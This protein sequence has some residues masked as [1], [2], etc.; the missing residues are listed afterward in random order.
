MQLDKEMRMRA[1]R[2]EIAKP[3]PPLTWDQLGTMLRVQRR[4]VPQIM[5]AGM[6]ARIACGVVKTEA[7]KAVVCPETKGASPQAVVYQAMQSELER[8]K[9]GKWPDATRPALDLCSGMV[10]ACSQRVAQS[11]AKRPGFNGAQP[12]PVRKQELKVVESEGAVTI[13]MKLVSDGRV[14]VIARPSKGT[15]WSTLRAIA[16]GTIAHGDCKVV[17]DEDRKKWYALISY[18]APV[19]ADAAVSPERALVVHRGV[20][21][22]LTLMSTTGAVRSES[23]AKLFHQLTSLEARMKETRR[24]S[25]EVIGAGSR[26]HGKSRRY[27]HYDAL[28]GKRANVVKTWCQQMGALVTRVAAENGCGTVVIEEYGGIAPHEDAHVRR[29]LI[30]FPMFQLKQAIKNACETRGL[31]LDEAPS[32][33]VSSTCPACG[34]LDFRQHNTRTGTFHCRQCSLERPADFV[35]TLN[36]LRRS[37]VDSTVWDERM[38]KV[39]KLKREILAADNAAE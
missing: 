25:P 15:H 39:E 33:Y 31:T 24:I 30:R 21:N 28:E 26:G 13:E 22:A 34:S 19:R 7:V 6:D 11:Y 23:G 38:A 36:M 20:R 35:A 32:E 5:R 14:R 10:A 3:V 17:Y 8:I 37:G 1:L 16:A 4:I 9:E 29:A 27:A 12:I 18:N 2:V